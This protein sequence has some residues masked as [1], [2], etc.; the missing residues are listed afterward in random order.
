MK[1]IFLFFVLT[2]C[3]A[4]LLLSSCSVN[5]TIE[6]NDQVQ[7]DKMARKIN[8]QSRGIKV[9]VVLEDS[10]RLILKAPRMHNGFIGGQ[11]VV[12]GDSASVH[13]GQ[14]RE[15]QFNDHQKGFIYGPVIGGLTGAGIGFGLY[16]FWELV[17]YASTGVFTFHGVEKPVGGFTSMGLIS[18]IIFGPVAGIPVK[19]TI[20]DSNGQK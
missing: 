9:I 5:H 17:N 20:T 4:V 11:N 15:I 8:I 14:I 3:S 19:Y 16:I 13:L 6:F 1:C 18:G 2:G 12:S 10:S 7:M